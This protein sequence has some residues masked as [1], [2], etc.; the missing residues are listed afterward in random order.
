MTKKIKIAC[1]ALILAVVAVF[2][3]VYFVNTSDKSNAPAQVTTAKP[4]DTLAEEVLHEVG[5]VQ[6]FPQV[7][8]ADIRSLYVNNEHGEFTIVRRNGMLIIDGYEN[9]SLDYE[10]LIQMVVNAGF[11]LSEFRSEVTEADFEKYG[12]GEGQHKAY[13]TLTTTKNEV[14]TVYIGDRTLA[15]D[16]Y[17]V[18]YPGR[19]VIYVL[20]N[21]IQN[22]LLNTKE[23]LVSKSIVFPTSVNGYLLIPELTIGRNGEKYV[24][25][26]FLNSDERSELAAS[27]FH[28]LS[29]PEKYSDYYADLSY[30]SILRVLTTLTVDEVV[31]IDC[32]DEKLLEYGINPEAPAYVLT[33]DSPILDENGNP[34]TF[35]PNLLLISEK[36]KDENGGWFYYTYSMGYVWDNAFQNYHTQEIIGK[37]EATK[38]DFLEWNVE[39]FASTYVFSVN[40]NDVSSISFKAKDTDVNFVLSGDT[41]EELEVVE[42]KSGY[43][44]EIDNFRQLWKILLSTTHD[45]VCTLTDEE[46]ENL[47]ANEHT[48]ILETT[49]KTKAGNERVYKFYQYSERRVYYTVNG[50]GLFYVPRT[51][52]DKTISDIGRLMKGEAIESDA[53]FG[54]D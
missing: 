36:Q 41:N 5:R 29:F 32:S 40:I 19:N 17:Y 43:T 42:T 39:K 44:P 54:N 2:G 21:T 49:V 10:K 27:S 15:G 25:V 47:L 38:L 46:K 4:T 37:I 9:V 35:A 20:D 28:M 13:F 31:S 7:T 48:L 23:Y 26:R 14:Y 18:R 50:V 33:Y 3:V 6:M 34:A 8:S 1:I 51:M 24:S 16:G 11:T 45:G 22:D 53:R 12:L 52:I 30:T